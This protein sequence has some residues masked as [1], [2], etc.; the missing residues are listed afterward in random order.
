[1]MKKT[2]L[3]FGLLLLIGSGLIASSLPLSVS[4]RVD[5]NN[6]EVRKIIHLYA[7]YLNSNPESIYDNPYWNKKE[8]TTLKDFDLSREALFQI[9]NGK[10]LQLRFPPFVLSVDKISS[11][12][13][14]RVLYSSNTTDIKYIGSKVWAIHQLY[15]IKE[16]GRWVLENALPNITSKWLNLEKSRVNFVYPNNHQFSNLNADKANFFCEEILKR[17]NTNYSNPPFH[18]F[19]TNSIDQMGQLENFDF[20]FA[21]VTS[22]KSKEGMIFT[23]KGNEYYPHEFVHQLLPKNSQRGHIIEEGLATYLGTREN[24]GE[25]TKLMSQLA[26]DIQLKQAIN[27]H[28][29]LDFK[30]EYNGYQVAYPAGAAICEMVAN[31]KGDQGLNQLING[32]TSNKQNTINLLSTILDINEDQVIQLWNQTLLTYK[33]N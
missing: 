3:L 27:F 1:M 18:F 22:G 12:Y 7:N 23:A 5:T 33:S 25:Y 20:Y 31:R 32:N 30:S 17:F 11:K 15:A 6:A 19:I 9:F 16:N 21:G 26:L 28:N 8:K 2:T 10:Q 4:N 13:K 14:I 24:I 29:I